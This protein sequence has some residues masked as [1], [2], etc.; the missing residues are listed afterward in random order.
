MGWIMK[1]GDME[2]R[3]EIESFVTWYKDNNLSLNVMKNVVIDLRKWATA[4]APTSNNSAE[5]EM[6]ENFKFLAII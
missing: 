1:K 5:V 3:K 4:H 2:Y 6:V